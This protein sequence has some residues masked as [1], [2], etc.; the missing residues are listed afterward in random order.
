VLHFQR[1][2]DMDSQF[3][4]NNGVKTKCVPLTQDAFTF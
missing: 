2:G 4:L 1:S 3:L